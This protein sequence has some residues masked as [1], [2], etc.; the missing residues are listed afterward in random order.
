[1]QRWAP[2][3]YPPHKEH[4]IQAKGPV[5]VFI[6]NDFSFPVMK[7]GHSANRI[8][9]SSVRSHTTRH[10]ETD[11]ASSLPN[12]DG[13]DLLKEEG[14]SGCPSSRPSSI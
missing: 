14:T 1:M 7:S 4:E 13:L 5:C 3:N 6:V 8:V 2:A 9:G 10:L 11:P 12:H